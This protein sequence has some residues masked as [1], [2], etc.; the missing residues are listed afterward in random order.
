MN[1]QISTHYF[2]IKTKHSSESVNPPLTLTY[3]LPLPNNNAHNAGP[4]PSSPSSV[5]GLRTPLA[6]PCSYPGPFGMVPH[7]GLNGELGSAGA[8]YAGLP[9]ISP[10]MSA[11]AAAV[12]AYGRTQVVRFCP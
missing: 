9:T 8:A 3:S 12:A 6:V 10:Q 1:H 7:P 4:L 5:P 11:V 2:K